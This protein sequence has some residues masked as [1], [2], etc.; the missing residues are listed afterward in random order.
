VTFPGGRGVRPPAGRG[1]GRPAPGRRSGRRRGRGQAGAPAHGRGRPAIA[2]RGGGPAGWQPQGDPEPRGLAGRAARA[3]GWSFTSSALAKLGTVG[4]GIMLARLLGPHAF[5]TYAVAYVALRVLTNLNDLGVSLAIVRWPG[6]PREIVPTVA[7]ISLVTSLVMYGGCYLGAPGYAAAMGAPAAAG[8][9]RVLCLVVV[10]DGLGASPAGLLQRQFRQDLRLITDQLNVWLGAVLTAALALAGLGPMSLALGRLAGC[11]G[12][13]VLMVKFS[14]QRLRFGFRRALAG[15]LLRFGLPLAGSAVITFAVV[16]ADQFVVGRLLGVTALGYFV[17]AS[18]LSSWPVTMFSQPVRNVAPA[19]LARLQHDPPAMRRAFVSVAGLLG[20]VALPVCLAISGLAV[21]LVGFVY[22]DRWL[23]AA[24]ALA[25]LAALAALQIAFELSYDYFVVLALSRVVFTLQLVWLVLLVPALAAGALVGGISGA[26]Q[27]EI[28]VAAGLALPWYLRELRRAGIRGRALAARLALPLAGA[29]AAGVACLAASR[30]IP[31]HLAALAAGGTVSALVLAALLYRLRGDLAALLRRP[32]RP[33]G[34]EAAGREAAGREAAVPAAPGVAVAAGMTHVAEVADPA[35][36]AAS[37]RVAGPVLAPDGAA[38]RWPGAEA[39]PAAGRPGP[40]GGP[41]G[42]WRDR[43]E[44]WRGPAG[45]WRGPAGGWRGPAADWIGPEEGWCDPAGGW[46]DPADGWAGPEEDW[47]DRADDP[48]FRRAESDRE[49][50]RD[51][52]AMAADVPLPQALWP[53]LP[54]RAD[55]TGPLPICRDLP[56]AAIPPA[57]SGLPPAPSGLPPAPSG[58]PPA[59]S[60]LPP[61]PS[62]LP[63]ARPA[64]PGPPPPLYRATARAMGWAPPPAA[65][66]DPVPDMLGPD[67]LGPDMLG[68]DGW[69]AAEPEPGPGGPADGTARREWDPVTLTWG[70]QGA[71]PGDWHGYPPDG[72]D[73]LPADWHPDQW[74]TR[75]QEPGRP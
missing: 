7:T 20:A 14:P 52:G 71:A 65:P 58:L 15:R 32:G 38:L 9:V 5:G 33:A 17:L 53:G 8:V 48:A 1:S 67:M 10:V 55:T 22:G 24:P 36:S 18:N 2:G 69:H 42:G 19:A 27:A 68:P 37:E 60:G 45:G 34:R 28:A 35:E 59:P 72:A 56:G 3:V 62:G 50:G 39:E 43:A 54:L 30:F 70:P 51:D 41:A 23:P 66:D 21:P 75:D 40:A 13:L 46:R 61:A 29:A 4:I 6:D 64:A 12:A 47:A 73:W 74:R 11:L 57:P 44:G 31:G 63:R 25:W 16:N 49:P 26:A